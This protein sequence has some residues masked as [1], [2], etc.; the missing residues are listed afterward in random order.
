MQVTSF[1]VT[2]LHNSS[3]AWFSHIDELAEKAAATE[4]YKAAKAAREA[5]KALQNG[6]ASAASPTIPNSQTSSD[7]TQ[8]V[9]GHSSTAA[10]RRLARALAEEVADPLLGDEPM[11]IAAV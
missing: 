9:S 8:D 6:T 3:V 4:R 2:N 5:A 7:S 10:R 1:L 11:G